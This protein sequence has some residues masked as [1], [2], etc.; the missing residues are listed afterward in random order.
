VGHFS[1]IMKRTAALLLIF[2]F[3]QGDTNAHISSK[4]NVF[5]YPRMC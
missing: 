3:N 5:E 2:Q 4:N 1:H